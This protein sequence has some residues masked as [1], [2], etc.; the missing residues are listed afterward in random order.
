MASSMRF[1]KESGESY[2][3]NVGSNAVIFIVLHSFKKQSEA[4]SIEQSLPLCFIL[5]AV[6]KDKEISERNANNV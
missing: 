1:L 3:I 2:C 4:A 5:D 6:S